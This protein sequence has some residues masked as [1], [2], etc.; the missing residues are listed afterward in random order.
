MQPG[1]A[2]R[3]RVYGFLTEDELSR[4]PL[5]AAAPNV[6]LTGLL[7]AAGMLRAAGLPL[8]VPW[9]IIH[10][11]RRGTVN[12]PMDGGLDSLVPNGGYPDATGRVYATFGSSFRM[13]VELGN[14]APR[15][16]SCAPFGNSDD[17]DSPHY[18]DQMPLAAS[19]RFR[20]VPFARPDVEAEA[21]AR[22]AL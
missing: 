5:A 6:A 7:R 10:R 16:W 2:D 19:R 4:P 20:P 13:L 15:A 18:A 17:P 11:H 12:L 3:V 1:V 8:D 14:G 21:T 22:T 9:G